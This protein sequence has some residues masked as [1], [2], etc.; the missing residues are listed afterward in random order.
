[1]A[2]CFVSFLRPSEGD[3]LTGTSKW[4][5]QSAEEEVNWLASKSPLQLGGPDS[6]ASENPGRWRIAKARLKELK[7]LAH[8]IF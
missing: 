6:A 5:D 8:L 2:D 3:W 7:A 1:M 4:K